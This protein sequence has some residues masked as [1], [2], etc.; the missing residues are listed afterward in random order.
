M[1]NY[2]DK[3][4]NK[5]CTFT[6]RRFLQSTALAATISSSKP[7]S[8][9]FALGNA[10][11]ERENLYW[12]DL[13]THTD[14]SDGNGK[15]E[16]NLEVAQSHLDFW[17]GCDHAF[18]EETFS[19][20]YSKREGRK[21]FNNEWTR[22][23]ALYRA[24][25]APGRFIPFLGYEWTNC[26]YGHHN[27]YYLDYDQP[28]HMP[29]TLPELY[30]AVKNV[31]ALVIPH[32]PGYPVGV[33]GKDWDYHDERLSPFVEMY[34][35]HGSSET[36]EGIRPVLTMGSWMGPGA[37]EGCAQAALARGYK[38]GFIASTDSH[39]DHPGAYDLGLMG[40]WAREL[41]RTSLWEAFKKRRVYAVT[42]DRISLDFAINGSPMGSS[43]S[44]ALRRNLVA[45]V[46]AWNR[47]D[48]VEIL[49]NNAVLRTFSE[50]LGKSSQSARTR[51][52]F[53][54]EW[55][56]D[57]RSEHDW[58]GSLTL[59]DGKILQALPC[60]RGNLAKRKGKG[61]TNLSNSRCEWISKTEKSRGQFRR[62]ADL[63]AF[64]VECSN[65]D[66]I[67]LVMACDGLKQ[68]LRMSPADMLQRSK[69]QYME[70][71]PDTNDGNFWSRVKVTA[72]F[73][74]HQAWTTDQLTV[75][76]TCEDAFDSSPHPEI[77]DFYYI[78][79]TQNNGQ[80]AW[81]SPIWVDRA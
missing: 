43:L 15:F 51:L 20:D 49:K 57:G 60:Y 78:R 80:R 47:I 59:N 30:A 6:R 56:W 31:D 66:S 76:L 12:G 29:R 53:Q 37:G 55:G 81:S 26:L 27:V 41:T 42:G 22:V 72:K 70:D 11:A 64:E 54:I 25:E 44:P 62:N 61:I 45:S 75:N 24:S 34:S 28:I 19:L 1:G 21:L 35:L 65:S 9:L 38:I 33:C 39:G 50:P 36:P 2:T 58:K 63:I 32:H 18:G 17:T 71:L 23:Q 7:A 73:K 67:E 5:N 79:V 16:D 77:A 40:V 74:V 3:K 14:L 8:S 69:A 68:T 13:H 10:E 52:R 48:R 46:V 4:A